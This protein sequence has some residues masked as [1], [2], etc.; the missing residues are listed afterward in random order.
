MQTLRLMAASR[1]VNDHQPWSL[2][3]HLRANHRFPQSA[4]QQSKDPT[5]PTPQGNCQC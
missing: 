4:T 2:L 1:A 5:H 3:Q